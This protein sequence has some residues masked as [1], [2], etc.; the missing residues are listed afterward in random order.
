MSKTNASTIFDNESKAHNCWDAA[1]YDTEVAIQ[2]AELRLRKLKS[3]LSVFKERREIG[4]PFP[5]QQ[6]EQNE[7]K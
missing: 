1:I 3:A 2:K 5:G 7:V 4:E 6:T